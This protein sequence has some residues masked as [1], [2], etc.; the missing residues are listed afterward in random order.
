MPAVAR[1]IS[2]DDTAEQRRPSITPLNDVPRDA[3]ICSM[4]DLL[5]AL[6]KRRDELGISLERL[7]DISGLPSGYAGELLSPTPIKNLG[8]MSFGLM[9]DSMG[10][11]LVLVENVEQAAKVRSRWIPRARPQNAVPTVRK[12][13]QLS[14]RK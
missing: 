1:L 14:S 5:S 6:R 8:W 7:D 3:M 4:P 11:A 12:Q 2:H 9:L 13:P 10:V